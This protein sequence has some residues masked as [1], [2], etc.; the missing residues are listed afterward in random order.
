MSQDHHHGDDHRRSLWDILDRLVLLQRAGWLSG[1][2]APVEQLLAEHP[3]LQE[4]PGA[5]F[6]LIYNELLIREESGEPVDPEE[7]YRRFPD[8]RSR[9]QEQLELHQAL[10][11]S[12]DSSAESLT[13]EQT[14][15]L[16]PTQSGPTEPAPF[17]ETDRFEPLER[18]GSGG[19]G[20]VYAAYDRDWQQKVA[21]KTLH[22]NCPTALF[23]L[24]HEFRTLAE[25]Q[26]PHLVQFYELFAA[27]EQPFFTMERIIGSDFVRY[28]RSCLRG[29]SWDR[30]SLNELREVLRQLFDG[31]DA[32]HRRRKLHCD[33]KPS[34]VLVTDAGRVVLLDFGLASEGEQNALPAPAPYLRGTLPYVAPEVLVGQAVTPAADYY[35]VGVLLFLVLTGRLPFQATPSETL[36]A[37]HRDAAPA[38][39]ELVSGLPEDL[40]RLCQDLLQRGADQR[41]SAASLRERLGHSSAEAELSPR[42]L[43][44][45][46]ELF[47]GRRR[48]RSLLLRAYRRSTDGEPVRV[49]LSGRSGVG[50][51]ALLHQFLRTVSRRSDALVLRGQCYQQESVPFKALDSVIDQLVQHWRRLPTGRAEKLL[52]ES[53]AALARMFP[54]LRRVPIVQ[55]VCQHDS[56]PEDPQE[57]RRQATDALREL[58]TRLA[59]HQ[60][61]ILTIDDLQWGDADSARLLGHIFGH[62][63]SPPLLLVACCREFAGEGGGFLELLEAAATGASVWTDQLSLGGLPPEESR[64]LAWHHLDPQ[65][66]GHHDTAQRVAEISEGDP[67]LVRELVRGG[68]DFGRSPQ[69]EAI[70]HL[71]SGRVRQL[72]DSAQRVLQVV[73]MAGG[74]LDPRDACRAAELSPEDQQKLL[75]QLQFDRFLTV[76]HQPESAPRVRVY[77]DRLA[78]SLVRQLPRELKRRHHE[79]LAVTLEETGRAEPETLVTHY[80]AAGHAESA[81]KHARPAANRAFDAL[82]FE[83]SARLCRLALETGCGP[84]AERGAVHRQLAESLA[85]AGQ[86]LDAA[87]E[88]ETLL[89]Q[90][91][92]RAARELRRLAAEQY[93]TAGQIRRCNELL[94]PLLEQL[95]L[96]VPRAPWKMIAK[97]LWLELQLR[98]RGLETQLRGQDELSAET[99]ERLDTHLL[100]MRWAGVYDFRRAFVLQ[101]L[102][103]RDTLRQ[104]EPRRVV[105]TLL[106]ELLYVAGPGPHTR[107]RVDLLLKQCGRLRQ[108]VD[109]PVLEAAS[110]NA[111]GAVALIWAQWR[112]SLEL[113]DLASRLYQEAPETLWFEKHCAD[114][115]GLIS[116]FFLGRFREMNRRIEARRLD[117]GE[118]G[119]ELI[120]R[121]MQIG[122]PNAA[123]LAADDPEQAQEKLAQAIAELPPQPYSFDVVYVE[124]AEFHRRL[125]IGDDEQI[126]G[127]FQQA[128][129]RIRRSGTGGIALF[130]MHVRT[131]EA[132]CALLQWTATGKHRLLK[133]ARRLAVKLQKNALAP[134]KPQGALIAA[135][136][137]LIEGDARRA[138]ELFRD[139]HEQ[140]D[141]EG[142][143]LHAAVAQLRYGE[144]IGSDTGRAAIESARTA[145]RH[146][147]IRNPTRMAAMVAPVSDGCLKQRGR[148]TKH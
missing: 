80:L 134:A 20:T 83:Q 41:P 135:Q 74:P 81:W 31:L 96:G 85:Q 73:A 3:E 141:A 43:P 12:D 97:G 124:I 130:R 143:A 100:A 61:V 34:N 21:L 123:W 55:R 64:Q 112:Q 28:C 92:G 70:D 67:F 2:P 13:A 140:F 19:M 9:L 4:D 30:S 38:P 136:L 87:A 89:E 75:H 51:T 72:S 127:D 82:A 7:F 27:G 57:S 47:V 40:D 131:V 116:L 56:P 139:A 49:L 53:I 115:Y 104:G 125:Y 137:A 113:N 39:K 111:R 103:L 144:T 52:P 102:L 109:A 122:F 71:L 86:S 76:V 62:P 14:K 132:A 146:Q 48:E 23:R 36:A 65:D 95:E 45:G 138:A 108:Q 145:M 10:Q 66:P 120:K 121:W 58:L 8:F 46:E 32:L 147:A 148:L 78:E 1:K 50:K 54:V 106:Y 117:P 90:A 60:A 84:A 22:Y 5:C 142:M 99:L 105:L 128:R 126:W 69:P 44:R 35:S 6:H 59:H 88:Y 24:K 26:H 17:P 16:S 93:L 11:L 129:R 110:A 107:P 63:E 15:W 94:W 98:R 119:T 25:L 101:R 118:R 33:I 37:K 77:H 29:S 79:K 133:R 68:G 114:L 42:R 18:L 91:S